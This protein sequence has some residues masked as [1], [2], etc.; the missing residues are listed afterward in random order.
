VHTKK[1]SHLPFTLVITYE[2]ARKHYIVFKL[3]L[4]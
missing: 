4:Y 2:R 1:R 3:A